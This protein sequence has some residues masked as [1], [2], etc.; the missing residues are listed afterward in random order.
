MEAQTEAMV[1]PNRVAADFGRKRVE[2]LILPRP[3]FVKL[4]GLRTGED[5]T[6]RTQ[7][8]SKASLV[9]IVLTM[10][11]STSA[12]AQLNGRDEGQYQIVRAFY[13]TARRNV[14]VTTRLRQLAAQD[15]TFRMGNST[16][17]VDP[18]QGVIKTLR[19]FARD[20]SGRERMFEYA[21][22]SIVDGSLFLGWA[23]G[24]WGRDK[25]NGGWGGGRGGPAGDDGRPGGA[26][27][28]ALGDEGQYQIVQGLYGTARRN[29]DV[30]DRLRQ[31]AAQ[32]RTF[33]MGNSTFGIDPDEGVIKTLRIFARDRSGRERMFEY[34]EGSTVDGAL[35]TGWS[36]GNWGRER[37]TGGWGAGG[38]NGGNPSF[39]AGNGALNIVSATYGAGRQR[40]DVTGRV[41]SMVRDGRLSIPVNND[42]LGGDPAPNVPKDLRVVFSSGRGREREVRVNEGQQLVVP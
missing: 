32:D 30:T 4:L 25:W 8:V 2:W 12:M 42:V 3:I 10:L 18:D 13:G 38:N 15:R 31:L 34:T 39:D 21:E 11:A 41:R 29:V 6:M 27:P 5:L 35:F 7:L 23:S 24:N 36:S 14:D 40:R 17:G 22:G 26:G 20:R 19:I 28:G 37:R 16:F 9:A 33:R 1:D